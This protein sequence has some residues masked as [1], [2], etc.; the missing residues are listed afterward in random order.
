[1]G[2]QIFQYYGSGTTDTHIGPAHLGLA[3]PMEA[4][5]RGS[6]DTSLSSA[7]AA[8]NTSL[9]SAI[10]SESLSG[11]TDVT[12]TSPAYN[13]I[14]YYSG[15]TWKNTPNLWTQSNSAVTLYNDNYDLSL[16]NIDMTE[17]GGS[18]TA[19]DMSVTTGVTVGTEESYS[20]NLD[21]N[22]IV[23]IYGQAS[24]TT[25]VTNTGLVLDG[26]YYYLGDPTVNGSWRF[27]INSSGDLE[28][29][30]L[31]GGTWTYKNKFT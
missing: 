14:L 23:R 20:F 13:D 24:G 15:T 5:T 19:I 4:S 30:K 18:L 12:I 29:D 22:S 2:T 10:A 17:D 16:S 11:L 7:I 26:S 25:G 9:S 21:G 31:T 6:T 3:R 1:M 28:F 8:G 27:F